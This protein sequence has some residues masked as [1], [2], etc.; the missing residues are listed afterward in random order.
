MAGVPLPGHQVSLHQKVFL[1]GWS[2]YPQTA[3][4]GDWEESASHAEAGEC[5]EVRGV[6]LTVLNPKTQ[7]QL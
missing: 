6:F 3:G 4:L 2:R 1:K 7:T 5:S